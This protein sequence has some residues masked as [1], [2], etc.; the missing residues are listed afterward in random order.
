MNTHRSAEPRDGD[1]SLAEGSLR[2]FTAPR[3][4]PADVLGVIIQRAAPGDRVVLPAHAL[5]ISSFVLRGG[6]EG[7]PRARAGA[8][9]VAGSATRGTVL[10]AEGDLVCASLLCRASVL[11]RL[12]GEP[13][14][15][16]TD[17][18]VPVEALWGDAPPLRDGGELRL[19]PAHGGGGD[20]SSGVERAKAID[21]ALAR[22]LLTW[23]RIRLRHAPAEPAR[24]LSFRRALMAWTREI[25]GRTGP[26]DGWGLR[27]WQ[28]SCRDELGVGP[29][30]LARL[31]RL[32][33]GLRAESGADGLITGEMSRAEQALDI[34][35]CDQAHWVRE[36]RALTGLAPVRRAPA[37]GLR[38][39]SAVLAPHFFG[40]S[41]RS[42]SRPGDV[43]RA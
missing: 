13:A 27:Q 7:L 14:H 1:A 38:L 25:P 16:F 30:F 23:A 43:L 33:A 12:S 19:G 20:G 34:G 11:P 35:C 10:R 41:V 8:A 26:P 9:W 37:D 40:G 3:G 2:F 5:A 15:V 21:E 29:K 42:P 28:R 17:R 36:H 24:A 6:F 4:E 39:A 18:A 31:A 32:H 22:Q